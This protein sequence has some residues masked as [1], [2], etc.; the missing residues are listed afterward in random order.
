MCVCL[1]GDTTLRVT[2]HDPATIAVAYSA[3]LIPQ[4]E[5]PDPLKFDPLIDIRIATDRLLHCVLIWFGGGTGLGWIRQSGL[6][7]WK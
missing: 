1:G 3:G 2:F 7:N 4:L 5:E 6:E